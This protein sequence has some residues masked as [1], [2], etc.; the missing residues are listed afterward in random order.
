M[1]VDLVIA[2]EQLASVLPSFQDLE[3]GFHYTQGSRYSDYVSGDKVATYGLTALVAGGAAAA[4]TK[5]GL[6][7]KL[8]KLIVVG[9][10]AVVAAIKKFFHA[11]FGKKKEG[12]PGYIQPK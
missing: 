4:A 3:A 1:N 9:V 12:E 5:S 8:W 7:A 2:P 6:L 10:L 11:L